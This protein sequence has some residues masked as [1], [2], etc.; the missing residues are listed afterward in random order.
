METWIGIALSAGIPSLVLA[1]ITWLLKKNDAMT[2][3]VSQAKAQ[4]ENI[5]MGASERAELRRQLQAIQQNQSEFMARIAQDYVHR[6]D[7]VRMVATV[8][9]K[10]DKIHER[11]NSPPS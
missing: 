5:Q 3:L 8:D 6:N 7:W 10:L 2:V 4:Q 1:A 11:L 9:R